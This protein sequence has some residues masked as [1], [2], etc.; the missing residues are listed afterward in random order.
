MNRDIH[1]FQRL[2]NRFSL[3]HV[4][5]TIS[6]CLYAIYDNTASIMLGNIKTFRQLFSNSIQWFVVFISTLLLRKFYKWFENNY[7]GLPK[8]IAAIAL[9]S[10]LTVSANYF[11]STTIG[12][13][14]NSLTLSEYLNYTLSSRQIIITI[15]FFYPLFLAWSSLYFGIRFW[16]KSNYEKLRAE[17]AEKMSVN[18]NLQM[19]R[20]QINP[21]FLFNAL[22]SINALISENKE[23]A[24][25]AN[26][27]LAEYYRYSLTKKFSLFEPFEEELNSIKYYLEIEKIRF[28]ENLEVS[29]DIDPETLKISVP[30]F[31]INP[32]VENAIKHGMKLSK[33]PLKIKISSYFEN[34][35]FVIS[36][37]NTGKWIE[38]TTNGSNKDNL[39]I[40]I[41]NVKMRLENAYPGNAEIETGFNSTEVTV[42]IIIKESAL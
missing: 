25:E 27:A 41:E 20:Y 21:H 26:S 9:I 23:K 16:L 17:K 39:G 3:F 8:I 29:Y 12:F 11:L 28:E 4:V 1:F 6:W 5:N 40:G 36:V 32:L 34:G 19:L 15:T 18:A 7:S 33:P 14:F 13:F 31:I 24:K 37:A 42:R 30:G 2:V 22:N 10:F 38:K 35:N